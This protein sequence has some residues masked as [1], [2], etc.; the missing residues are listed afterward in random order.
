VFHSQS[1][2][3]CAR[4]QYAIDDITIAEGLGATKEEK[5]EMLKEKRQVCVLHTP[6]QTRLVR[7]SPHI[8]DLLTPPS[9]L[10]RELLLSLKPSETTY[11][12][13]VSSNDVGAHGI[14]TGASRW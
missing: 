12:L 11:Q 14:S 7:V 4:T 13:V 1:W 3:I 6:Q 9:L 10:T 5:N 2:W 8:G